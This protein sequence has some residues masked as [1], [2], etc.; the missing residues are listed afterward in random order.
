MTEPPRLS[1]KAII[2]LS[3]LV[4]AAMWMAIVALVVWLV[5]G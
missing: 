3:A 1:F 5:W 2:I 4:G